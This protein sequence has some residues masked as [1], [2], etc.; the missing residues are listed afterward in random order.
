MREDYQEQLDKMF[1]KGYVIVYTFPESDD[2]R[3]AHYTPKHYVLLEKYKDMI[4]NNW[5]DNG[6]T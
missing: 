2:V 5:E 1:P 4:V 3:C 6:I